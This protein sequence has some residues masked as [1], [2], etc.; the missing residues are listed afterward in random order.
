[1]ASKS[2]GTLTIDLVL[3]TFGLKQGMDKS[4][5]EMAAHAKKM[6]ALAY[7]TGEVI[8]KGIKLGF[9]AAVA[10]G[11]FLAA[12]T[13]DAIDYADQMRDLSIR[14]GIG[15]EKLSEL[16]YAAR[17]T[18][19]DIDTLAGGMKKL[20][21]A[22]MEGLD[23]NSKQ[24]KLFSALGISKDDLKNFDTLIPKIA[25]AFQKMPDGVTKS[26][27]AMELFGKSGV[28]L[29]EFLNQGETGLQAF[30]ERARELGIVVSQ[31]TATKADQ[32]K[33]TLDDLVLAVKGLGLSLAAE[34]LP[35]LID[36]VSGFSDL[37]SKGGGV[38]K[39]TADMISAFSDL[40]ESVKT[41]GV[42]LG[43][44]FAVNLVSTI[45]A[46]VRAGTAIATLTESVIALRVALAFLTGPAGLIAAAATGLYILAT[47]ETDAEKAAKSHAKAMREING[48]MKINTDKALDLAKSKREEAK[49]TLEAAKAVLVEMQAKARAADQF[50]KDSFGSG[51]S[52]PF[53][54][55]KLRAKSNAQEALVKELQAEIADLDRAV[56]SG[57]IKQG[58]ENAIGFSDGDDSKVRKALGG[59]EKTNE[60]RKAISE[61]DKEAARLLS[62]YQNLIASQN[63]QIAL[64]GKEDEV[65]KMLYQTQQGNLAGLSDLQKKQLIGNAQRLD[66]MREEAK[67]YQDSLD[68]EEG[69]AESL[70]RALDY[71]KEERDTLGMTNEQ[72]EI[73]QRLKWLGADA[74][75]EMI[76]KVRE[77]TEALQQQRK[78]MD[79]SIAVQDAWRRGMADAI[80]DAVTGAKSLKDAF[81]SFFDSLA[82]RITQMI[83]NRW[84]EQLFGQ[85]GSDGGGSAGGLMSI[86]GSLFGGGLAAGGSVLGGRFYEVGEG[87]KPELFMQGGREY[88]IPGNN[89]RVVPMSGGMGRSATVNQTFVVAGR[90]DRSTQ[91]QVA[92][93]AGRESQR[94][95]VRA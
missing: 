80:T 1:M 63:E 8:G 77:E 47:R 10:G 6:E 53:M 65:S 90:M 83:A 48:A 39:I 75:D 41:V 16:A 32:F 12:I 31:D 45:G 20:S 74:T 52:A 78:Q 4:E 37:I 21:K 59:D 62:T 64:F 70:R 36:V 91:A 69:R 84:V 22:A 33:D 89:G 66:Q 94:A 92:R 61:A 3:K 24:G 25:N 26:A 73:Y 40:A 34:L 76:S 5:R 60:P 35:T 43:T 15:T 46:A 51:A 30:A 81:K 56:A 7:K 68:L 27:V 29:T 28:E 86:I 82:Q 50:A 11:T 18:G 57:L 54:A 79:D 72:L 13:K 17:S 67:L 88:L 71:I 9:G 87:N 14:T 55:S 2:L 85:M 44:Y 42:Y 95:M 38:Q 58:V 49:A 23:S 93:Q 19:A